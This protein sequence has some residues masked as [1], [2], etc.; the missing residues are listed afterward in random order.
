MCIRDSSSVVFEYT[1]IPQAFEQRFTF[2]YVYNVGGE[3]CYV[4][5]RDDEKEVLIL[6]PGNTF[7]IKEIKDLPNRDENCNSW[8]STIFSLQDR[9]LRITTYKSAQRQCI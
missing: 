7:V 5:V 9:L 4:F 2:G 3:S 6:T 1:G 8:L